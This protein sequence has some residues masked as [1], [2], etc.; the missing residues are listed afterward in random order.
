MT[1]RTTEGKFLVDVFI[2]PHALWTLEGDRFFLSDESP[3]V[4]MRRY[5]DYFPWSKYNTSFAHVTNNGIIALQNLD[6]GRKVIWETDNKGV[7]QR[8]WDIFPVSVLHDDFS[9]WF[10]VRPDRRKAVI[11]M[12]YFDK[13]HIL[14]FDDETSVESITITTKSGNSSDHKLLRKNE[15]KVWEDHPAFYRGACVTEKY[16]YALYVPV[17]RCM[18]FF[19]G[20][21]QAYLRV[22]D[23]YGLF[24]EEYILDKKITYISVDES[25]GILYGITKDNTIVRYRISDAIKGDSY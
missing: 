2:L 10:L 7:I 19:D 21:F 4:E 3:V 24:L 9:L 20:S 22:F 25:R 1:T 18:D 14:D 12:E 5:D 13:I 23:W 17:Q 15:K 8:S 6:D 11:L 16:I